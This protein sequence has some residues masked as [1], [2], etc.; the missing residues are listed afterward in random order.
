MISSFLDKSLK[1]NKCS[2]VISKQ[3]ATCKKIT[4]LWLII[5]DSSCKD[6]VIKNEL[7]RIALPDRKG[8]SDRP[9][10]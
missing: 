9:E 5:S 3:D 4:K 6:T 7:V 2:K 8:L 10:R 1:N